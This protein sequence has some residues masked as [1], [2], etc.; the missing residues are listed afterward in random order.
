[1]TKRPNRQITRRLDGLVSKLIKYG[2]LDGIELVFVVRNVTKNEVY[3]YISSEN[4][5]WIGQIEQMV[6]KLKRK[7]SLILT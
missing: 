6:S 4:I 2:E 5:D 3:S 1:M 7:T